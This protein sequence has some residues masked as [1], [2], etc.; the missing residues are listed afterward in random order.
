[1]VRA[2]W[3]QQ[4]NLAQSSLH[5]TKLS[6]PPYQGGSSAILQCCSKLLTALA[7]VLFRMKYISC[8]WNRNWGWRVCSCDL[9][10]EWGGGAIQACYLA[11]GGAHC[12]HQLVQG[13]WLLKCLSLKISLPPSGSQSF[14]FFLS[15]NERVIAIK[16]IWIL[17]NLKWK[18]QILLGRHNLISAINISCWRRESITPGEINF[19]F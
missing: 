10:W 12:L 15:R 3:G 2:P 4:E 14:T 18:P 9:R 16:W 11:W 6:H 13:W 19:S 17:F 5:Q 1:M 8:H 7:A